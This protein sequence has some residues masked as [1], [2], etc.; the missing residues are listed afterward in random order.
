MA[1]LDRPFVII[2][3]HPVRVKD[4][5]DLVG[6]QVDLWL[7]PDNSNPGSKIIFRSDGIKTDIRYKDDLPLLLRTMETKK[8]G[9]PG[10]NGERC[11]LWQGLCSLWWCL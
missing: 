10:S 7:V 1:G 5:D 9:L 3:I 8:F 6:R 4:Y 2:D 11:S